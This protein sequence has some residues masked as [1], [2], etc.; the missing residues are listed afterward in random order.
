MPIYMEDSP[1]LVLDNS[2]INR[3]VIKGFNFLV[4]PQRVGHFHG[5]VGLLV[6]LKMMISH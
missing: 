3:G 6:E 4:R 2:F 5:F 1:T